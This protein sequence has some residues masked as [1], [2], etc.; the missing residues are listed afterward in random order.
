MGAR[1]KA[2]NVA[3]RVTEDRNQINRYNPERVRE[4]G[5][6]EA[7]FSNYIKY[8]IISNLLFIKFK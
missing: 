5:S 6:K 2:Y 7:A 3:W 8:D 1:Q 4:K